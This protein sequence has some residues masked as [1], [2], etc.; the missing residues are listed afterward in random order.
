MSSLVV[1]INNKII[2]KVNNEI[3]TNFELKNKILTIL[4]LS[5]QEINQQNID[6]YKKD[7]LNI[8]IDNK[9]KK[10]EVSK[11]NII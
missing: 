2:I 7:A 10:I 9:L 6:K 5:N 3:I 8:L 4:V 11:Y 1:N